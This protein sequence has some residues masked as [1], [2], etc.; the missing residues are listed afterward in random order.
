MAIKLGDKVY[1]YDFDELYVNGKRLKEAHVK[2]RL[3]Y[4]EKMKFEAVLTGEHSGYTLSANVLFENGGSHRLS[5][6][7]DVEIPITSTLAWSVGSEKPFGIES[8]Q[9]ITAGLIGEQDF[10]V[11]VNLTFDVPAGTTMP[12]QYKFSGTVIE[13]GNAVMLDSQSVAFQKTFK[14]KAKSDGGKYFKAIS[15]EPAPIDTEWYFAYKFSGEQCPYYGSTNE[16]ITFGFFGDLYA[17]FTPDFFNL[18]FVPDWYL[19]LGAFSGQLIFDDETGYTYMNSSYGG[20]V[21][22]I[23]LSYP[24]SSLT[25]T[26]WRH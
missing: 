3:V 11:T 14:V 16:K 26:E 25:V 24:R 10:I 6:Y 9:I 1:K 20:G 23:D 12:V 18:S 13:S 7:R 5:F 22:R 19:S 15:V 21:L 2:G 4:P 8:K 17:Y